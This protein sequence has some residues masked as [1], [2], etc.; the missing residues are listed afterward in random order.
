MCEDA[1]PCTDAFDLFIKEVV[2]EMTVKSG[3]KCTAIRRAFVPEAQLPAVVDALKTK[4][5]EVTVGDPRNEATRTDSL[6]NRE[7]PENVKSGIAALRT[8]AELV[9]R[10]RSSKFS[11]H[12][13][14]AIR[15]PWGNHRVA[16]STESHNK[17]ERRKQRDS[18]IAL[19]ID[20]RFVLQ[21]VEFFEVEF[22]RNQFTTRLSR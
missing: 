3:Q 13:R 16:R 19:P 2:R 9:P 15:L 17:S 14:Q 20:S 18:H 1:A 21:P 4:L 12:R 7:Q 6:V 10:R 22:H 5:A 11:R 8:E